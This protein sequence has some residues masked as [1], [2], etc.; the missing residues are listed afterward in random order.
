MLGRILFEMGQNG[1]VRSAIVDNKEMVCPTEKFIEVL[2]FAKAYNAYINSGLEV[3]Y[4]HDS[5]KFYSFLVD[6]CYL[7]SEYCEDWRMEEE[8]ITNPKFSE[9]YKKSLE[10]YHKKFNK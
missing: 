4:K 7:C 9:L 1:F 10:E 3:K 8:H 6:F 2:A 5:E